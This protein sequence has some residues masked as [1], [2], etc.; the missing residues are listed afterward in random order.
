M[1][2]TPQRIAK[3]KGDF[4]SGSG[5][6][7]P[8]LLGDR[9]DR[10]GLEVRLQLVMPGHD[11]FSDEDLAL[12]RISPQVLPSQLGS[13]PLRLLEIFFR[14]N[15]LGVDQLSIRNN[16]DTPDLVAHKFFSS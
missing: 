15:E 4:A 1:G 13:F 12:D 6:P 2:S 5:M 16:R 9:G 10:I 3:P 7:T 11:T 8:V 14:G